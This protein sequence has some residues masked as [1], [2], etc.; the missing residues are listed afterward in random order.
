MVNSSLLLIAEQSKATR[1]MRNMW[2]N[3]F[4]VVYLLLSSL[5][6]L[7]KTFLWV[8]ASLGV[9]GSGYFLPARRSELDSFTHRAIPLMEEVEYA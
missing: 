6:L 5:F 4:L 9:C 3:I 8:G 7:L 1:N 2:Q